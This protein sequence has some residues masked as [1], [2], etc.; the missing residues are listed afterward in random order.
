MEY[1]FNAGTPVVLGDDIW[2]KLQ[3]TN[4]YNID[5]LEHAIRYAHDKRIK[6]KLK[7]KN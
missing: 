3:N 7:T 4:S 1:A 5:N 2:S 6:V